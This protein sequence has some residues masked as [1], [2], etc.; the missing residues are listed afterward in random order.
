M[1][2]QIT[3]LNPF[4]NRNMKFLYCPKCGKK[5]AS[6]DKND[7]EPHNMF[8]YCGYCRRNVVPTKIRQVR[9]K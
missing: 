3:S 9:Y 2:E 6:Y 1:A 4:D 5:L 8:P 7:A